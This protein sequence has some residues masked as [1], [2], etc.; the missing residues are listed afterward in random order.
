MGRVHRKPAEWGLHKPDDLCIASPL[1]CFHLSLRPPCPTATRL[2]QT[3]SEHFPVISYT[4]ND[5]IPCSFVELSR[6][7]FSPAERNVEYTVILKHKHGTVEHM[8]G[9]RTGAIVRFTRKTYVDILFVAVSISE[10]QDDS[11]VQL[12]TKET[13]IQMKTKWLLGKAAETVEVPL[14][15]K[16][17]VG[18]KHE[19]SLVTSE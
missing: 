4:Q 18:T 3:S 12:E 19:L 17:D 1:P 2:R 16:Q 14:D 9:E 13:K 11:Y 10:P 7:S 5:L 15:L 6:I 8:K